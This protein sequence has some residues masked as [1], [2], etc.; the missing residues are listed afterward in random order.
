LIAHTEEEFIDLCCSIIDDADFRDRMRRRMKIADLDATLLS[1]EHVPAFVRAI[2]HLLDNH[3][4]LAK[5]P[6]REPILID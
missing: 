2:D 6:G 5:E 1:H 3:E 4:R